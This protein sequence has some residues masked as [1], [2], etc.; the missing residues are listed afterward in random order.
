[1]FI[2]V[3]HVLM[4][5]NLWALLNTCID[6]FNWLYNN[7]KISLYTFYIIKFVY[8]KY[9]R[10]KLYKSFDIFWKYQTQT[11]KTKLNKKTFKLTKKK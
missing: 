7:E 3:K 8:I 9:T 6:I 4:N 11:Y 2:D 1:M 10:N 5:T